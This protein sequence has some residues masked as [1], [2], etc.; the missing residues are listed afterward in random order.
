MLIDTVRVKV[1]I[2]ILLMES[3][4]DVTV[5]TV[6]TL[7]EQLDE[8]TTVSVLL[9]G[10][11]NSRLA[12]LFRPDPRINYYESTVNLG[13]AGGRNFLLDTAECKGS[14]IVFILDNDVVPPRDYVRNLCKFLLDTEDAGVVG[15]LAADINYAGFALTR[16]YGS[17]GCW[18]DH[19]FDLTSAD[20][21]N[22]T[23]EKFFPQKLFH[24]GT[25]ENFH[26]T[27]FSIFSPLCY[28]AN[29]V[30]AKFGFM[31]FPAGILKFSRPHYE[32]L[33]GDVD[34]YS[35]ANVAGCSQAFRRSL[36]GEIGKLNDLFN[37]YG[38]EDVDFCLRALKA[39]F[40]NYLHTRTWIF[41]GTDKRHT[42]RNSEKD[43]DDR[44][45]SAIR[46]RTVLTG[47]H[48]PGVWKFRITMVS[49]MLGYALMELAHKRGPGFAGIIRGYKQGLELLRN[50]RNHPG[51]N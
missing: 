3:E 37:P 14:D 42:T 31:P 44:S 33:K 20:I 38:F 19:I 2:L 15:A 30:T 43:A 27:Y 34:R 16:F 8:D 40:K 35:V 46:G 12:E 21:R 1:S 47:L 28:I 5:S 23:L 50:S 17:Q 49:V 32:I 29:K 6:E 24:I 10:G 18:G 7:V 11:R 51:K 45:Q 26:F 41:H 4:I 39:G 48:V 36:V 25:N 9:N 22:L 13:V